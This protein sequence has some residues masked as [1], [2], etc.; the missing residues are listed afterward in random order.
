MDNPS[1]RLI[2]SCSVLALVICVCL[3]LVSIGAAGLY[4][5]NVQIPQTSAPRQDPTPVQPASPSPT[6]ETQL[7][8]EQDGE[9]ASENTPKPPAAEIPPEIAQQMDEIQ[10]QVIRLRGLEPTGRVARA[11]LTPEELRQHVTENFLDDYTADD[12]HDDALILA[13]FGL[14]ETNFDLHDFLLELYSEQVAGFYDSETREMFVLQGNRFGGMERLTYA[15]EYTHALQDQNYNLRD[16]LG[17]N[18][19]TCEEDPERCN[20]ILALVEGDASLLEIQW[21]TDHGTRQDLADIQEFFRTNES[22]VFG[23][24][25]VFLQED[26]MFPYTYG[27]AFVEHLYNQGGWEAVNQAYQNPPVSTRQ[28][29]HPEL[30]PANQPLSVNLPDFEAILG[31][32]WRELDRS[33]MGEWYT[34]LILAHGLDS[35]A[36][37][38]EEQA[39]SAANGWEGDTYAVYFNDQNQQTVMVLKHAW[40]DAQEAAEFN[41]AFQQYATGRFGQ[42]TLTG[43]DAVNWSH[44]GGYTG[45]HVSGVETIWILAPDPSITQAI[46]QTLQIR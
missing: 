11:L 8:P 40:V 13:A 14:L 19:E 2:L 3:S 34:Y 17:Y 30:Y 7:P 18:D 23:G 45:F 39:K 46:L 24:A 27:Q 36:R 35:Q 26:F 25:P 16:G 15:H 33:V 43:S 37:L 32:G 42:P 12:A 28:I 21:F 29:L 38:D 5:W 6:P 9:P 10:E 1:R 31:D 4:L 41:D 22:P 20:A 44:L